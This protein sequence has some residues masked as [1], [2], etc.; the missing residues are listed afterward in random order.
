MQIK[1]A[2]PTITIVLAIIAAI[3]L[4]VST[5][6]NNVNIETVPVGLQ[7]AVAFIKQFFNGSLIAVAVIWLRNVWGY[8]EAYTRAKIQGQAQLEYDINKFYKT[9]AYYLGNTAVIFNLAPTSELKAI[10]VAIV[11]FIDLLGSI[12]AKIF[13]KQGS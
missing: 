1:Q 5:A 13:T 7:Q 4:A 10:G 11:F 2:L 9:A 12:L 8:I 6:I 3:F